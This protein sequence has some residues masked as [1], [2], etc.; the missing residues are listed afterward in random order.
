MTTVGPIVR[1]ADAKYV[2]LALKT[3]KIYI[4]TIAKRSAYETQTSE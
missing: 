3:E 4:A 2:S 1:G